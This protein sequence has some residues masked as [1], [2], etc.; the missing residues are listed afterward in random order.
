[1]KDGTKRDYDLLEEMEAVLAA[2]T[3]DRV[4]DHL[5]RLE[6]S[7]SGYQISR[8]GHSLQSAT[9]AERDGADIDWIVTALLHDI[10]DDLAPH[11]HD[12]IA[13]AVIKPYVRDECTWVCQ[14]HGIFQMVYYAHHHGGDP[15][16]RERY[17]DHPFYQ[18]AVDFCE[19]WDQASFDP[20]YDTLTLEHFA[21][22]IHE[23]FA[24]EPW[25]NDHLCLGER[26]PLFQP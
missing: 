23:V 22:M 3:A 14:H 8:L 6:H 1:M 12:S 16:V 9:R 21:P 10:G 26:R 25:H 4:L 17:R 11:N 5:K 2:G 18:A 19:R 20:S 24:R 15:H 7:F 13:A